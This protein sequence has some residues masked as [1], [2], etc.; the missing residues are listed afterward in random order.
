[1]KKHAIVYPGLRVSDRNTIILRAHLKRNNIEAYGWENGLNVPERHFFREFS[2][3]TL[4]S[5]EQLTRVYREAEAP[6][7]LI[8]HS[9]GGLYAMFLADALP[10]QVEKVIGLGT[11]FQVLDFLGY[12][13]Y[14]DKIVSI[15]SVHDEVIPSQSSRLSGYGLSVPVAQF[16]HRITHAE[17]VKNQYVLEEIVRNIIP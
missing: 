3:Y 7:T 9:F 13:N 1:M 15:Y 5:I 8:G 11:P 14:T 2:D 17:L 10:D 12:S 6:V 4:K 16:R